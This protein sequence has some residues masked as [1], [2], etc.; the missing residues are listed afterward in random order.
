MIVIATSLEHAG[1]CAGSK[2]PRL[3]TTRS[4]GTQASPTMDVRQPVT[5]GDRLPAGP[6]RSPAVPR[7]NSRSWD[8]S[9]AL[10]PNGVMRA[11]VP[12]VRAVA[13]RIYELIGAQPPPGPRPSRRPRWKLAVVGVAD[14]AR[15]L[16]VARR[17]PRS[18]VG[19]MSPVMRAGGGTVTGVSGH[20]EVWPRASNGPAPAVTRP[21]GTPRCGPAWC[22]GVT[23][24]SG[25][26]GNAGRGAFSY[27]AGRWE[28]LAA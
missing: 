9:S 4:W 3:R 24:G 27:A 22:G 20:I 17:Q 19:V 11:T 14:P 26:G 18:G 15:V 28:R 10:L 21:T 6:A 23:L 12:G 25:T 2:S 7:G 16:R 5:D 1:P 13:G 8:W